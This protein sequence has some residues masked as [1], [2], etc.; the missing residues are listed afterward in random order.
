MNSKNI[1]TYIIRNGN[2]P[3]IHICI[4]VLSLL[5]KLVNTNE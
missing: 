3:N 4:T 5:T 1:Y 2:N